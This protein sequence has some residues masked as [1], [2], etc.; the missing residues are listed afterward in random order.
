MSVMV[1]DGRMGTPSAD[2]DQP[3]G[4]TGRIDRILDRYLRTE[5]PSSLDEIEKSL[6]AVDAAATGTDGDDGYR[7]AVLEQYK[8]YVEMA[9]RVS[10]RRGLA[11]TFFLTLNT[12]VATTAGVFWQHP[13][14]ASAL[15][16]AAPLA[17][18]LGQCLAW[19]WILRSYRQLN[20][21]KYAVL[22]ALERRLPAS[23][24]WRAEWRALGEGRNPAQY[25]PL[26]HV[27]QVVPGFFAVVYLTGFV[28]LLFA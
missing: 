15:F 8:L 24:Y 16:A 20:A 22:G 21:A 10:A 14:K 25:W 2:I 27:E 23:P 3:S 12:A 18:L 7:A 28:A 11:N 13:P 26:S 6:W 19:F 17:A 5:G 4:R 1:Q 9:D